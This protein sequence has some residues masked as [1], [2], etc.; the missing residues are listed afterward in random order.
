MLHKKQS[1]CVAFY[2]R[3][4]LKVI[5]GHVPPA[6]PVAT[7]PGLDRPLMPEYGSNDATGGTG[8]YTMNRT[9]LFY[10]EQYAAELPGPSVDISSRA[11]T[12]AASTLHYPERPVQLLERGSS[13]E[14]RTSVGSSPTTYAI[15]SPRRYANQ[16][17]YH[18]I[19]DYIL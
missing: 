4:L 18:I 1:K 10:Q 19:Y 8:A 17:L 2:F 11:T 3:S 6:P 5:I 7:G 12:S 16:M 13:A 14:R 9:R 15:D